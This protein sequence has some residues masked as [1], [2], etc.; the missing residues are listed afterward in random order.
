MYAY[1]LPAAHSKDARNVGT[2]L[3]IINKMRFFI[4]TSPKY[5]GTL[6]NVLCFTTSSCSLKN[7]RHKYASY[8]HLQHIII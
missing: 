3:P 1:L 8:D 5:N 7:M 6:M 2:K 4:K